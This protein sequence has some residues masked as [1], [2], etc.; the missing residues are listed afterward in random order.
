MI[1]TSNSQIN[2][3]VPIRRM[4]VEDNISLD[5]RFNEASKTLYSK[6]SPYD[7]SKGGPSLGSKQPYVWTGLNDSNFKKYIKQY[8]N[9]TFPEG[10]TVHDAI[11]ITK[12]MGSGTGIIFSGIQ[13][14]LQGQNAFNETRVWNP[15]SILKSTVRKGLFGLADRPTRHIESSG[16]GLFSTIL[17][18]FLSTVGIQS[19]AILTKSAPSGTATKG[20]E[21]LSIEAKSGGGWAAKGLTRYETSVS[22]RE[23]FVQKFPSNGTNKSGQKTVSS[24]L[25]AIGKSIISKVAGGLLNT[26]GN[27]AD[28]EY[29]VEYS[30][31]ADVYEGFRLDRG[32]LMKYKVKGAEYTVI[33]IHKY[34]PAIDKTTWYFGPD[35]FAG[36]VS[37]QLEEMTA[38]LQ[39]ESF[40]V[41]VNVDGKKLG[42]PPQ[43][44]GLVTKTA[45]DKILGDT[46]LNR[47]NNAVITWNLLNES[48]TKIDKKF[49]TNGYKTY[50]QL[51]DSL[52]FE[53]EN[54]L[55]KNQ[56]LQSSKG[57]K[58]G[59]ANQADEYNKLKPI[60][61][62]GVPDELKD[63]AHVGSRDSIYFY[64]F[65]LV[66]SVYIP[67]R[68]TITGLNENTSVD[69]ED[70]Q[71]IG[72][73]DKLYMYKGFTR[74]INF[75]FTV[76][77]NSVS[78]LEPMWSRINY[79]SG[80][81]RPAKYTNDNV[82]DGMGQ[83]MY[84]PLVTFRIGDLFVDQPAVIRSFGMTVP[85]DAPW[86]LS[87]SGMVYSY[88]NGKITAKSGTNVAQ[89]PMKVD[90]TLS[91][92]LLEKERSQTQGLRYF[93]RNM[94]GFGNG[95]PE[96]SAN[97]K[98]KPRREAEYAALKNS[99]ASP[100]PVTATPTGLSN[101]D[102][103][104]NKDEIAATNASLLDSFAPRG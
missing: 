64:F 37:S 51:R 48:Y 27:T 4:T 90:L 54:S 43:Q 28:W 11:R 58:F 50:R 13:F 5:K 56:K 59:G 73:S 100:T 35:R 33:E 12:F 46:T 81:T 20:L 82:K 47:I 57:K 89:L 63:E 60:R 6:F 16:G 80:L 44:G 66:N 14:S 79:L 39:S 68:A 9:T 67:F 96:P 88:N 78:E 19:K 94:K 42:L 17:D 98:D 7:S 71:Y 22:G 41:T 21:A 85:D 74:E 29:K 1:P 84:P 40:D 24:F 10:S 69:W 34:A 52:P 101:I 23:R 31:T 18:G 75:A 30:N 72:R 2:G 26:K 86:E 15:L 8:D 38:K 99:F 102:F 104:S 3:L 77:A 83:F 61:S 97:E 91:M 25:G 53:Y 32:G 62:E 87:N 65:D 70:F 92:A 93:D 95:A 45:T 76:Y 36:D 49:Y 103:S 55:D